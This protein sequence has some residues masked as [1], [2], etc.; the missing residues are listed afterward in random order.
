MH[1]EFP[2]ENNFKKPGACLIYH[3]SKLW[4]I[5]NMYNTYVH[6]VAVG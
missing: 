2:D 4:I 6:R 3:E 1:T 5:G